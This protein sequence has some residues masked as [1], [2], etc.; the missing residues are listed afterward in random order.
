M[1][2]KGLFATLLVTAKVGNTI[3]VPQKGMAKK[4]T[5]STHSMEH[6]ACVKNEI[7]KKE[8]GRVI[9]TNTERCLGCSVLI[10]KRLLSIHY[11]EQWF[12]AVRGD[13]FGCHNGGGATGI[14]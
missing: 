9:S 1:V 7:G 13:S 14:L 11:L 6:H 12:S 10:P 5:V 3:N 8:P 4:L 2:K